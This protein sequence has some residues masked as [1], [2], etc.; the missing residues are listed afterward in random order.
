MPR[1]GARRLLAMGV[2]FFYKDITDHSRVLNCQP[3]T[4]SVWRRG[5]APLISARA[6]IDL[7][8]FSFHIKSVF[9]THIYINTLARVINN[10]PASCYMCMGSTS[11]SRTHICSLS[12][13]WDSFS[14]FTRQ[15]KVF[16]GEIF[17]SLGTKNH[18]I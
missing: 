5:A 3:F 8:L 14:L 15:S 7:L 1:R 2:F 17:E 11:S 6:L 13:V 12:I 18:F 9:I 10:S 4:S 16:W